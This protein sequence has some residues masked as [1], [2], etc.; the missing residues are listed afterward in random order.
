MA[1]NKTKATEASVKTHLTSIQNEEQRKDCQALIDLMRKVTKEEPRMWGPS[2]IGFGSYHYKYE[3]GREGDS[4]VTGF[5]ARRNELAVYLVAEGPGQ[6]E[7]LGRLGKHKMGKAC[8]YL[9][10]LADVDAQV[11]EELIA[12][13]VAA[14]RRRY[15]QA[16]SDA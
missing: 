10:R 2:I 15:G 16:A 4:C 5:A 12:G 8:L 9:R 7:L 13:S 3:S 1:E 6:G 14:V 11:L